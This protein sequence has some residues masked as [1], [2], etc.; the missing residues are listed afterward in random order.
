[1]NEMVEEGHVHTEPAK[2]TMNRKQR[3]EQAKRYL[4]RGDKS[5]AEI[6]QQRKE[7]ATMLLIEEP[8]LDEDV[9]IAESHLEAYNELLEENEAVGDE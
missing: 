5:G 7:L 1:M 6:R 4:D 8:E 9:E 2:T 3:R